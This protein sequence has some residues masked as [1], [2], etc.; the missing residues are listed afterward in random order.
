MLSIVSVQS[1][2]KPSVK[3]EFIQL[4]LSTAVPLLCFEFE[5]GKRLLPTDEEIHRM[6][7]VIAEH[8]DVFLHR[9]ASYKAGKTAEVANTIA[10]AV[11]TMS[12]APGGVTLFDLHFEHLPEVKK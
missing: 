11:A 6:A 8:S 12:Y 10:L 7:H 4:F 9:D 3:L 2:S 5:S 1:N